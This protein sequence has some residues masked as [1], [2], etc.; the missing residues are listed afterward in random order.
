MATIHHATIKRAAKLGAEFVDLGDQGFR[1]KNIETGLL[2]VETFESTGAAMEALADTKQPIEW[3]EVRKGWFCGVM[4]KSYHDLYS[5]NPHGPGCGDTVDIA[6]RDA[7][8]RPVTE[9][10]KDMAVDLALLREIGEANGCWV[11]SYATLNPG[12]QRMNITNRLR[13]RLRNNPDFEATIGG[14]TGRFGVAPKAPKAKPTK[15]PKADKPA[16]A[17]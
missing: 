3:E 1:L 4:V 14:E 13:G 17:A 11:Q 9:G 6:M 8:M 5:K 10:S 2:S 12:M 16:K 7:I 15:A